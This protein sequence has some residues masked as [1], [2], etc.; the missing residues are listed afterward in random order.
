MVHSLVLDGGRQPLVGS[1]TDA[2]E[3]AAVVHTRVHVHH[4]E[5][6]TARKLCVSTGREPLVSTGSLP[7]TIRSVLN[8]L[9]F[10][11]G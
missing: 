5:L 11:T 4:H 9:A 8:A 7:G 2:E 6:A 3:V 1:G 10:S